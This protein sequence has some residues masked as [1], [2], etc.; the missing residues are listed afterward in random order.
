M[1][2]HSSGG[3]EALFDDLVSDF[4]DDPA[5]TPPSARG[6]RRFG[7]SAL[8]VD[9]KIFAMLVGGELVVKLPRERVDD[10]V[11]SGMG[12]PFESGQGRVMKE[13]VALDAVDAREWG[14]LTRAARE[15][16]S[17]R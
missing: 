10:L 4:S 5:V 7:A 1:T 14:K 3:A 13:W 12:K 17:S 9:G 15:F 2:G 8:K 16:V 11:D 6:G